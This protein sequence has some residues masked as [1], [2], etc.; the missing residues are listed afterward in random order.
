MLSES[1]WSR[2]NIDAIRKHLELTFPMN[3]SHWRSPY[4]LKVPSTF[5]ASDF[6]LKI[7]AD[8]RKFIVAC[9]VHLLI[10]QNFFNT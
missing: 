6:C 10:Y 5:L 1:A 3:V 9:Y 2:R 4:Q 7:Y 8:T